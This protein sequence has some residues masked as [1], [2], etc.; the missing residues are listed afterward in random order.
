MA[1]S[2]E[3]VPDV[4]SNGQEERNTNLGKYNIKSD[5]TTQ[6]VVVGDQVH[7]DMHFGS[8]VMYSGSSQEELKAYLAHAVDA[9]Q[10][11][12]YQAVLNE[13]FS[14]QPYKFLHAFEVTDASI[15]FGREDATKELHKKVLQDRLTVLHA[16]SGAGKSSL[17]KAGL[18][19]RLIRQGYVPL[20]VRTYQD[21]VLAIK[22][23]IAPPRV[24]PWPQVLSTLTLYEFLRIV[25]G[26]LEHQ[27]HEL[28]IILDQF[29]DFFH[30]VQ[31]E[32]RR[33]FIEALGACYDDS[34]L[35]IR[36][37]IALRKDCF[38]DLDEFEKALPHLH[39]FRNHYRLNT[40]TR[41]GVQEA[42]EKPLK[43]L[44][45]PAS[46]DPIL[47]N[48]LVA[49]LFRGEMELPL[50]QIICTRLYDETQSK[51][52]TLITP[53]TYEALGYT[54]GVLGSYLNDVLG[55]LPGAGPTLARDVLK[56]FVCFDTT[57]QGLNYHQLAA[58]FAA[59]D[60]ELDKL[61][62]RLVDA[63]LL[64][65]DENAG[66]IMY[67]LAHEYL[68]TEIV[69]WIDQ[70][71]LEFKKAEELL[72]REMTN[73][74]IHQVF[75]PR[76]RL[77]VLYLYRERLKDL[78][79]REWECLLSSA[80]RENFSV[81]DWIKTTGELSTEILDKVLKGEDWHIRRAAAKV[82]GEMG[83]ATAI[84]LLSK[85]LTDEDWH[86]RQAAA[87]ALGE[88]GNVTAIPH[89]SKALMDEDWHVRRAAAQALGKIG[90]GTAI[91]LLSAALSDEDEDVREATAK[92]LGEIG[93][94]TAISCLSK[95]LM[96]KS[97][98]VRWIAA[99]A[100]G[101]IG[102]GIAVPHLSK[103]L[104]DTDWHVR[105]AAAQA[106]GE[107]GDGIAVP[108]LSKVL[109]DTD[110]YVRRAAV[111]ALSAIDDATAIPLLSKALTDDDWHVRRAAAEALGKIGN[112]TAI[113]LLSKALTDEDWYM[114]EAAAQAL[115][116]I[117]NA[118]AIPHLSNALTGES[119]SV[120]QVAAQALGEIGDAAA[121]PD[122]SKALTDGD[123][124]VRRAVA[125]ALG[126]IGDVAAIPYLSKA[127]TDEDTYV[128]EAVAQ[129]LGK[130]GDTTA[131][132]HLSKALMDE[133]TY[134]RE[135]AAQ[136]LSKI[137]IKL[138]LINL[139]CKAGEEI[140]NIDTAQITA[141]V[142]TLV[143]PFMLY[144]LEP[145]KV[146]GQKWAEKVVEKGCEAAWNQAQALWEK[147]HSRFGNNAKVKGSALM[148]SADPD[149]E[150]LQAMFAKALAPHLQENPQFAQELLQIISGSQAVQE[151]LAER[152]VRPEM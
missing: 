114:R 2:K 134:V 115:G 122:L 67:E 22:H 32:E 72:K 28:V 138:L 64:R 123:W 65:R 63:R 92:A 34:R 25:C 83:D 96:D 45:I 145:S 120:R 151:V 57:E 68:L 3:D 127:L 18:C 17:L 15:F 152:R 6:G 16:K 5:G 11:Y 95:S 141:T 102:D 140:K 41:E 91:S 150:T 110:W 47:L 58:R 71:D 80:L 33:C 12:M 139:K 149:D 52:E 79:V 148:V 116:K 13:G 78:G 48:T 133:D 54:Q 101:E 86:V 56:E 146:V 135:A 137:R 21:P 24:G 113:P 61:L 55:Q 108:H 103:V 66:D 142:V 119:A 46:Y 26:H 49:D 121:I 39:I 44:G 97:A 112:A 10:V 43:V 143:A 69:K 131:I 38:S 125:Q 136:G 60:N 81:E 124:Q 40:M 94:A 87:K 70:A 27:K 144:L 37:V 107:I 82:L 36:F 130:I 128:R 84:P 20:Y 23:E 73:W 104:M 100:L 109:M 4:P 42:I 1:D 53:E 88:I 77:K 76:D 35:R 117:G 14:T 98:N 129:A 85:A 59:R 105:E 99:Q 29:E 75:I 89:L 106:L 111:Q 8:G 90:D 50:L 93:D 62:D 51:E 9:Y 126:E 74:Y 7:V 147:I 118:T 132:P 31:P 30:L 19:P